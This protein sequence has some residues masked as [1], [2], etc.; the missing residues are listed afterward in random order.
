MP[1]SASDQGMRHG[2]I[3]SSVLRRE[4]VDPN[5]AGLFVCGSVA[6]GTQRADSDI[7]LIEIVRTRRPGWGI[8]NEWIDGVKVGTIV[9][10]HDVLVRSV[11]TVPYLLHPLCDA[12]LLLDRDGTVNSL[13]ARIR[14]YF[15]EHPDVAAEWDERYRQLRAEK[16]QFG[17]ERTTIIEVWNDLEREHSS[18]RARRPFFNAWYL[19]N[20]RLF[21]LARRFL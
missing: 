15:E 1:L 8:A 17:C 7:D 19:T 5:V 2:S 4:A 16:A 10:T 14:R 20:P 3:V 9:L 18:G 21:A 13:Q 6:T 11:D 12:R